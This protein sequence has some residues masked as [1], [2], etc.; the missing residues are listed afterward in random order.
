MFLFRDDGRFGVR[1]SKG[2]QGKARPGKR[3]SRR[4]AFVLGRLSF[5]SQATSAPLS[6]INTSLPNAIR[7]FLSGE[8]WRGRAGRGWVR[9]GW[10]GSCSPCFGNI[11]AAIVVATALCT[12]IFL[13]LCC[14]Y[15]CVSSL[16]DSYYWC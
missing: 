3:H 4:Q 9:L 6:L 11:A 10:V 1:E 5:L 14:G 13:L 7:M 12:R 15:C 16:S 8:A 2:R